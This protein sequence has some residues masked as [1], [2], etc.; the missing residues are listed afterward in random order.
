[1]GEL[2]VT[3]FSTTTKLSGQATFVV[4]ANAFTGWVVDTGAT[5]FND[6]LQLTLNRAPPA[7]SKNLSAGAGLWWQSNGFSLSANSIAANGDSGNPSVSEEDGGG[8][9]ATGIPAP[10]AVC[11]WA[12]S[13]SKGA[14][15]RPGLTCNRRPSSCLAPPRSRTAPSITT[16]IPPPRPGDTCWRKLQP[17]R[18]PGEA[19]LPVLIGNLSVQRDSHGSR[20]ASTGEHPREL[21]TLSQTMVS[22]GSVD[23]GAGQALGVCDSCRSRR[24]PGP[25]G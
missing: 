19:D 3:R 22:P 7:Y 17:V 18:R 25:K 21:G 20:N 10:P 24:K 1:M 4:G 5:T 11:S 15:P 16:S 2:Q 6:D 8:G 12:I 14:W 13:R 9:S 23:T